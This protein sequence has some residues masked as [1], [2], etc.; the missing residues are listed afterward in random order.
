MKDDP[1][2]KA[3]LERLYLLEKL[4]SIEIGAKLGWSDGTILKWLKAFGIPRRNPGVERIDIPR[5]ELEHH[6]LN[7]RLSPAE[8][9]K[10]YG[11][12]STTIRNKLVAYQIPL[13]SPSAARMIYPKRDFDGSFLDKVYLIGLRLGDFHVYKPSDVSE[14]IIVRCHSTLSEQHALFGELFEPYGHIWQGEP[15]SDDAINAYAYLNLTFD[16]LLPKHDK[17]ES[18]IQRNSHYGAAFMAGYIDA[19]G[20]FGIYDGSP[21]FKLDSQ[22]RNIVKWTHG[23]LQANAIDCPPMYRIARA[24]QATDR[25][26]RFKLRRDVWRITVNRADSLLKMIEMIQ[27]FVRHAKGRDNLLAALGNVTHR[28]RMVEP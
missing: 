11:C 4:S 16:F 3:D 22:D 8:I 24:G 12:E 19:E 27:P 6:Y 23:W 18:W 25:L 15:D 9:G 1:I 7:L 10:L 26:G 14:T 28:S 2:S 5:E 21:R 17:V 13:H 20:T